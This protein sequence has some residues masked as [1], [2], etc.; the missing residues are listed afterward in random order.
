M[1]NIKHRVIKTNEFVFFLGLILLEVRFF[2]INLELV[3]YLS[4]ILDLSTILIFLIC[5]LIKIQKK[6][7]TKGNFVK[8]IIIIALGLLSLA[9]TKKPFV[10]KTGLVILSADGIRFKTII[11]TDLFIKT[12]ILI[13]VILLY[14]SGIINTSFTSVRGEI[15]RNSWGFRHPNT[16]G[17]ILIIIFLEITYLYGK[18][19]N[20]L[21]IILS[22]MFAAFIYLVPNS[23][24]PLYVIIFYLVISLLKNKVNENFL[25]KIIFRKNLLFIIFSSISIIMVFSYTTSPVIVNIDNEIM[26]NRIFYQK[27]AFDSTGL[28][29][30]GENIPENTILDNSYIYVLLGYGV[31]IYYFYYSIYKKLFNSVMDDKQ[32]ELLIIIVSIL[33]YGVFENSLTN[34]ICNLFVLY[35]FCTKE[36]KHA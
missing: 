22:I 8:M 24:A 28:S 27:L 25:N 6:E 14:F 17:L 10:L 23:R 33:L 3:K 13:S 7:L 16:L 1:V 21:K 29:L 15:L 11:R 20:A 30:L 31:L 5:I 32:M 9:I 34:I 2:M 36:L 19:R 4:L 35:P 12:F 26:S 18:E